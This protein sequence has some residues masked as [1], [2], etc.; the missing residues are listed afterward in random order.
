MANQLMKI[1]NSNINENEIIAMKIMKQ[2]NI[3]ESVSIM[4]IMKMK[5]YQCGEISINGV[6]NQYNENENESNINEKKIMW[7]AK[8]K[9]QS[10]NIRIMK[11]ESYH[12]S[13][14][15]MAKMAK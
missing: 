1:I 7:K 5:I 3:N 9:Y 11:A 14:Q 4:K 15:N 12:I 13:Y 8:M 2:W 10:N 6:I